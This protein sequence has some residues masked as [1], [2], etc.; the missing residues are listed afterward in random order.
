[1]NPQPMN[2]PYTKFCP[3]CDK[4]FTTG[5]FKAHCRSKTHRLALFEYE[6][7]QI[8]VVRDALV[9]LGGKVT[10]FEANDFDPLSDL[11]DDVAYDRY[12]IEVETRHGTLTV[13][14]SRGG[15]IFSRFAPGDATTRAAK[16][17]NGGAVFGT[18][19]PFSGKYNHHFDGIALEREHVESFLNDI[20]ALLP[21]S[22]SRERVR[23]VHRAAME[24]AK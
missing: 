14:P 8:R 21:E 4:A 23:E 16:A 7:R 2:P 3:A 6:Q 12:E 19:N 20:N 17:M 9:A 22:V 24:S 15:T 5:G 1:M 18:V 13:R 11:G 10:S